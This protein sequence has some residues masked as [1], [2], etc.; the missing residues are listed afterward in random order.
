MKYLKFLSVIIFLLPNIAFSSYYT[1]V[2]YSKYGPYDTVAKAEAAL[3]SNA[4]YGTYLTQLTQTTDPSGNEVYKYGFE[5]KPLKT[6]PWVYRRVIN[7]T[8]ISE[9]S[10]H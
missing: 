3:K 6:H 8:I 10:V 9:R 4:E 1:S 5:D 7:S 2:G